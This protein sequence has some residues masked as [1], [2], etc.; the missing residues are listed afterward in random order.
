MGGKNLGKRIIGAGASYYRE[1]E[2]KDGA[3]KKERRK[4]TLRIKGKGEE[5]EEEINS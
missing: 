1:K 3:K 5:N 2:T 4:S